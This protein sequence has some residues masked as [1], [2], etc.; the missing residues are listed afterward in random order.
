MWINMLAWEIRWI[1]SH[2][3]CHYFQVK[4]KPHYSDISD[5]DVFEIPH[6]QQTQNASNDNRR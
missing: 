4:L 2:L 6:S 5:D 1:F 3:V